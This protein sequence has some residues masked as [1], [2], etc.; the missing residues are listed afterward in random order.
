MKIMGNYKN[1]YQ[2]PLLTIGWDIT[3]NKETIYRTHYITTDKCSKT[4]AF[5]AKDYCKDIPSGTP[6]IYDN[7]LFGMNTCTSKSVKTFTDFDEIDMQNWFQTILGQ[8]HVKKYKSY[9]MRGFMY[10]ENF[11]DSYTS[12]FDDFSIIE[13]TPPPTQE[14]YDKMIVKLT[15]STQ[16]LNYFTELVPKAKFPKTIHITRN[17]RSTLKPFYARNKR[18]NYTEF[19]SNHDEYTTENENVA[20]SE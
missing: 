16:E 11:V 19:K 18:R 8:P 15:T 20:F 13:L 9:V 6:I 17:F 14:H 1:Y 5:L 7:M 4:K 10:C 2:D 3:N 12:K